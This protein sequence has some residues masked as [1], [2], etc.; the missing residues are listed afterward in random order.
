MA[1]T[2]GRH[3]EAE[4]ARR[5]LI[6][7]TAAAPDAPATWPASDQFNLAAAL[8]SSGKTE[9]AIA[10]A[11]QAIALAEGVLGERHPTVATY[12][13]MLARTQN[14]LGRAADALVT[15]RQALA[16][17]EAWY[18]ADD[19]HLIDPLETVGISLMRARDPEVVAVLER[20]ASLARAA[21]ADRDLARLQNLLAMH[22]VNQGQLDRAAVAGAELVRALEQTAGPTA[23]ARSSPPR[24][25]ARTRRSTPR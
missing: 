19:P 4:A 1:S 13:T 25:A 7:L 23:G 10:A 9:A 6:D 15:G 14:N 20:A 17:L 11:T 16:E 22:H 21:G 8:I 12:R 18:G 2:A 3:D 5:A 24:A